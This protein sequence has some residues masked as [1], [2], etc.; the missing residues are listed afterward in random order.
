MYRDDDIY[1]VTC[2]E[3]H[4]S[5]RQRSLQFF[6]TKGRHVVKLRSRSQFRS[7]SGPRSGPKGPR[8]KDQRPGPGVTLNLVCHHSPPANFSWA[9][10]LQSGFQTG[11]GR[12]LA[13]TRCASFAKI[14]FSRFWVIAYL[15]SVQ[16]WKQ[17][18]QMCEEAQFFML[19]YPGFSL[20]CLAAKKLL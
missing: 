8:T 5:Q 4:I 14:Y 13:V 6:F 3:Y 11:L 20:T 12:G 16:F 18:V 19:L 10:G 1:A 7:R 9:D 15:Y 2:T 17:R